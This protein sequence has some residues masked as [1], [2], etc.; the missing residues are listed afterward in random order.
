MR[1]VSGAQHSKLHD[2]HASPAGVMLCQASELPPI[3]RKVRGI[4]TVSFPHVQISFLVDET[5]GTSWRSILDCG[6]IQGWGCHCEVRFTSQVFYTCRST[7]CIPPPMAI[8]AAS[9]HP[10]PSPNMASCRALTWCRRR[11][12]PRQAQRVR[13]RTRYPPHWSPGQCSLS[14]RASRQLQP[15]APPCRQQA[16]ILPSNSQLSEGSSSPMLHCLHAFTVLTQDHQL[17]EM[18]CAL[19]SSSRRTWQLCAVKGAHFRSG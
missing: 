6:R 9:T 8:T 16:A 18:C 15:C 2:L 10:A 19:M 14:W 13:P 12:C 17:Y 4:V 11:W 5:W 3:C 1:P 7:C